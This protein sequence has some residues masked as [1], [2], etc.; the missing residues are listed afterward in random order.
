ML[1]LLCV[2]LALRRSLACCPQAGGSSR[3]GYVNRLMCADT[4]GTHGSRS[5][6]H[7]SQVWHVCMGV[8]C[9]WALALATCLHVPWQSLEAR[10]GAREMST[11]VL[12]ETGTSSRHQAHSACSRKKTC[13]PNAFGEEEDGPVRTAT[14]PQS[15]WI[16]TRIYAAPRLHVHTH[17]HICGEEDVGVRTATQA[18]VR[19]TVW[20]D[21]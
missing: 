15:G 5:E 8:L 3:D 11:A 4:Y 9:A 1:G 12:K 10:I 2:L 21:T 7:P 14:Q 20:V 18:A 16:H 19:V 17:T 13:A 6:A